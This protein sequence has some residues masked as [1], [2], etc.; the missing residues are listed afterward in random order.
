MSHLGIPAK[1]LVDPMV[2]VTDMV[3]ATQEAFG[4][5][6]FCDDVLLCLGL[7]LS[8]IDYASSCDVLCVSV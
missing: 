6:C 3:V 2:S 7:V 5:C 1:S 8:V 4:F